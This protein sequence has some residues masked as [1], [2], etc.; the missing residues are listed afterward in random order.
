MLLQHLALVSLTSKLSFGDVALCAA[1]IQK[2]VTRD[3]API[4]NISA[5][6]NAFMRLEDI[7]LGYWPIAIVDQ[8]PIAE[9]YHQNV[10]GQPYAIVK[11]D[12]G[13]P[14]TV[15]HECIEMLVDPFGNRLV[16]GYSPMQGQGRVNFLVEVC[17]PCE[18]F[19]YT[20][21]GYPVCDF[22]TPNYFDPESSPGV[23]YC[24]LGLIQ[25][26]RQVLTGGYLSWYEPVTNKLWLQLNID[27]DMQF[28]SID[29]VKPPY[30]SLREFIDGYSKKTNML[31]KAAKPKMMTADANA[32]LLG[33]NLDKDKAASLAMA[34]TFKKLFNQ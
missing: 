28:T 24:Y 10:Y 9:G 12:V 18:A 33:A 34:E 3:V 13:W 20:V 25:K 7:P 32:N 31:Q 30:Q 4:W 22:Y 1:A 17:D 14:I 8:L 23:R 16:S 5:T 11:Y 27:G 2:Q 26:P 19:S 29:T 15:S 21:N 6:V